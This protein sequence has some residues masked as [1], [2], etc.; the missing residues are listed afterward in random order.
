VDLDPLQASA[1]PRTMGISGGGTRLE[2]REVL[3]GEVWIASGQSN[4]HWTF[5]HAILNGQEELD[6]AN[7]AA[8]RQFTIRKGGVGAGPVGVQG[9]W[10]RANRNELLSGGTNGDSALGYFFARE[11]RRQLGVPV[12]ILNAS[13]GGTPIEFWSNGG[14]L[15]QAMVQPMAPYA[16]A[17][18]IWYQ[19]ESNCKKLTGGGYTGMMDAM[20]R[21]WRGVWGQGDFPFAYVQ[22][23]P[24]TY[25]GRSTKEAPLTRETLPEFWMAQTG[26]LKHPKT[27]MAVIHDTVKQ[28]SDIHPT[29]KQEV[30]R[31]L[32]AM[33]LSKFYQRDLGVVDSPLFAG[34][35]AEGGRLRVRFEHAQN[36]LATRD[37]NAPTHLEVAGEDGVFHPATGAIEGSDLWVSSPAVSAPKQVRFAW[38]EEAISNLMNREGY[39]VAPFHSAKWPLPLGE[40]RR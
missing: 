12:G 4:M 26:Y 14:W 22:I 32:G 1:E 37:G 39:P 5:N 17:G 30:A 10:H 21:T 9:G 7:D 19:G 18:A 3:V 36:G 38:D 31:R 11:L 8:V 35:R 15:Y 20:V 23:A 13:V 24:F 28:V 6:Q 29:N 16:I 2:L 25:S 40:E 33:V 27:A 34:F